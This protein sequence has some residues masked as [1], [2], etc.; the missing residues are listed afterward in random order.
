MTPTFRLTSC[1][2][3][4]AILF[5]T[6]TASAFD[7]R[8]VFITNRGG[9]NIYELDENLE[10]VKAWFGSEGLSVPNG[11]AFTPDGRLYVADTGNHRIVGF[12]ASGVKIAEW[13][14]AAHSATAVEAIN[15]DKNGILYVSSN[16][17]DG[18]VARFDMAGAFQ[19]YLINDPLFT[20]LG[21]VNFTQQGHVI[22]S[23]FSAQGRGVR[24]LDAANGALIKTFGEEGGLYQEDMMVDGTDRVFVSR[25][26]MNDVAVFGPDRTFERQFT[27]TGLA[28][29]TGIVLTH[30]CRVIVAS[31]NTAEL[32][33]FRHDGTFVEKRAYP[34]MSLPESLAIVGQRLPGSFGTPTMEAV[35]KCDGSDPDGGVEPG[36]DSGAEAGAD[37][38]EAGAA[39]S[40]S[41]A[42]V[43][44]EGGAGASAQGG[45][46]GSAGNADAG[47][48]DAGASAGSAGAQAG[49][50][51]G[52]KDDSGCGC[53]TREDRP[54]GG[55]IGSVVVLGLA[56]VLRR[57]GRRTR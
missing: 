36:E 30:D 55:W 6:T 50:S 35:P 45:A 15:F 28:A 48:A 40:A 17:G 52:A 37:S 19:G 2:T 33:V 12:D 53:R 43:A 4:A 39:G 32:Y 34:G 9:G 31:F 23:D 25:Y 14:M 46:S 42:S 24:E 16:P 56:L 49:G 21:N 22:V 18:R 51:D 10:F 8:H 26:N 54:S 57:G 20:N 7:P 13:S 41:D 27:A 3:L 47:N 11:M 1:V 5:G 29:P 38:G 44:V